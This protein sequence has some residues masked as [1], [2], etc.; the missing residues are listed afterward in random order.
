MTTVSRKIQKTGF[1]VV[2]LFLFSIS[3]ATAGY[4]AMT[5]R[6]GSSAALELFNE[7]ENPSVWLGV[8]ASYEV[9]VRELGV[10]KKKERELTQLDAWWR[11][12]LPSI[13]VERKHLTKD[14]L[15]KVVFPFCAL[16]NWPIT[17]HDPRTSAGGTVEAH[18][19]KVPTSHGQPRKHAC[20]ASKLAPQP[21]ENLLAIVGSGSFAH[22]KSMR[23]AAADI[24]YFP[25]SD[26]AHLPLSPEPSQ[27]ELRGRGERGILFGGPPGRG[28]FVANID[29]C[30]F[31]RHHDD[32]N[33]LTA[34]TVLA[35][36]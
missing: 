36:R 11:N 19:R 10:S 7:E 21:I 31:G 22:E 13:L 3:F 9:A 1:N 5:L 2:S 4:F 15:V 16:G 12:Q 26:P 27:A 20:H 25:P 23:T 30:A 29:G 28:A 24:F 14:D 8:L 6:P 35:R 32:A 33:D 18:S 17:S 34:A